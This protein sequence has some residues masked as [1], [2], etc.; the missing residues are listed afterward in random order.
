MF[1]RA[2][3]SA[4]IRI[5]RVYDPPT[6]SDGI[7]IL[8]DRLWPRGLRRETAGLDHWSKE[9]APT[10]ELRKWFDHRADRFAAFSAKYRAQLEKDPQ[11]TEL[12]A[13]I[14]K[15]PATLLYAARDPHLNH[16]VVL[17]EFLQEAA[18]RAPKTVAGHGLDGVSEPRASA[19][20]KNRGFCI[21]FSIRHFA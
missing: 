5:K 2:I 17:A 3:L 7:R 1:W 20:C 15:A 14:G 12:L 8:V 10:T 18:Q 9:I 19:S 4:T 6:A 21:R 13:H 11:V 16:A